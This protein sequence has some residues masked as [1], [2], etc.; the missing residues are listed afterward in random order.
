MAVLR[1]RRSS[2]KARMEESN[3]VCDSFDSLIDSFNASRMV[4]TPCS[5]TKSSRDRGSSPD[6]RNA[7]ST[8]VDRNTSMVVSRRAFAA[9]SVRMTF[10]SL[11]Q[12]SATSEESLCSL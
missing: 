11:R 6:G 9:S 10:C 4:S 7:A 2:S 1:D 5:S 12:S 8:I 3:S